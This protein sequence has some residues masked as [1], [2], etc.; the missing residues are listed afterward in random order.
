LQEP[1]KRWIA[2]FQNILKSSKLK[3]KQKFRSATKY[4]W[5]IEFPLVV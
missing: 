4:P 2:F 5:R 3:L 1:K